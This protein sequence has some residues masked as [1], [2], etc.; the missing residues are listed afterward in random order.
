ML[1]EGATP[2]TALELVIEVGA[3]PVQTEYLALRTHCANAGCAGPGLMGCVGCLRVRY[4]CV[5][6]QRAHWP[7]H[8]PECKAA[9]PK[10]DAQAPNKRPEI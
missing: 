5:E 10:V 6:C 1:S 2:Y 3:T 9:A 4:C 7:T 8:E